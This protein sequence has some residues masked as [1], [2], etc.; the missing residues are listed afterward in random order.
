MKKV[1]GAFFVTIFV[2]MLSVCLAQ[3]G[4]RLH[5]YTRTAEVARTEEASALASGA[6]SGTLAVIADG[7]IVY[8]RAFGKIGAGRSSTPD[9]ETQFNAGSISKVFTAVAMLQLRERGKIDLDKPVTDYLPEFRM[10]DERYG[11]IT[12][13]MLL[14]HAAGFPGTNYYRLFT[15]H[16]NPQYVAQTLAGLR[17]SSLKSAPGDT[18]VYCNDCFTV[19]QAVIERMSGMRFA[20][21]VNSGIFA[22]AG[23]KN[24]SYYFK[25]GDQNV[26]TIYGAGLP[27]WTLSPEDTNALGSGG[28]STTGMDLCLFSQALGDG[29]LLDSESIDELEKRQR[30]SLGSGPS[31]GLVGLGWDDVAVPEFAARGI[32]MLSKDGFTN[33]FR[34]QLYVAPK[35]HLAVAA[36]LAGP[37]TLPADGVINL[38]KK[39]A[40]AAL[41][42]KGV[43]SKPASTG[44]TLPHP[45]SVPRELYKFE[46]IYGASVHSF[47]RLTF[48]KNALKVATFTNSG[49]DQGR[50]F[51]YGE[52]GRFHFGDLSF[53]FA[54]AK[55][56]R[57]LFEQHIDNEGD[58]EVVGES[59]NPDESADTSEFRDTTWV[60]RNLSADDYV[61]LTYGGLYKTA[62]I[63]TLPGV[64][65]LHSG[66]P[67]DYQAY[68]LTGKYTGKLI[69]PY[70]N[71]QVDVKI[72]Y[73]HGEK[74][75]TT[76]AFEFVDAKTVSP[77]LHSEQISI[78]GDGRNASRKVVSGGSF[79]SSIPADGRLL[80]Y[81]ADGTQK[82]D[83]LVM[84]NAAVGVEPG[85]IIVFIGNPGAVFQTE[86]R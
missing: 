69:L 47:A 44:K 33:F 16:Q 86:T 77:L 11:K 5:Q 63:E 30:G 20:D 50:D 73:Q 12:I 55:D 59:I 76:G 10:K 13:R 42:D 65:Y 81:S 19:A 45:G 49:F 40:W 15:T 56:G 6:F 9:I 14:N 8:A 41:E 54:V 83:S 7:K 37:V 36:I 34:S 24:S 53:S 71:D 74:I 58:V 28:M 29:K 17:D 67:G 79:S 75:L 70:G 27:L 72:I 57:N 4:D 52:E 80:G 84:K 39:V 25:K 1:F 38:A 85:S 22:P 66:T 35:E 60:P 23:M 68:G 51:H 82:F 62:T 31:L 43:V 2:L 3:A 78:G 21:Y 26:A 48:D 61:T 46:G 18:S 32:T 64:I